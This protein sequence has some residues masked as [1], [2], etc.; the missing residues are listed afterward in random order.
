MKP[1]IF[2]AAIFLTGVITLAL[3]AAAQARSVPTSTRI[4]IIDF[5]FEPAEQTIT[6]G[7]SI[8]WQNDGRE[9]HNVIDADGAWESPALS[10]G[11]TYTFTFTTPGT[12]TYFCS[13]HSGMLGTIIIAEPQPQTKVYVA[14]IQR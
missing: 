3:T 12:Y 10:N 9:P 5:A 8:T 1:R 13:I 14:T 4:A 7:E 6:S 11:Q 2:L